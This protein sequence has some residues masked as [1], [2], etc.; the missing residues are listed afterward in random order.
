MYVYIY[1]YICVRRLAARKGFLV[2]L[3]PL[4]EL[5]AL[6]PEPERDEAIHW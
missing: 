5:P 4:K 1:I 6:A 2:P 3:V